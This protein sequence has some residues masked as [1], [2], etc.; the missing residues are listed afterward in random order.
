MKKTA[1]MSVYQ[2]KIRSLP[3]DTVGIEEG[4]NQ[5]FSR[6]DFI[7]IYMRRDERNRSLTDC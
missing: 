2:N 7:R 4:E 5:Q 1:V 3:P 6:N